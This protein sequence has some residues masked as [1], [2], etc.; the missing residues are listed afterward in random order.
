M[1]AWTLYRSMAC[2]VFSKESPGRK[3]V[4]PRQKRVD[5]KLESQYGENGR[6]TIN[7]S[8]IRQPAAENCSMPAHAVDHQPVVN[9]DGF[10]DSGGAGG[11]NQAA[12]G[13]RADLGT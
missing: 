5:E 10:W 12:D 4:P 8:T 9:C 11:R 13:I 7:P 1:M 2:R 6:V 3:N